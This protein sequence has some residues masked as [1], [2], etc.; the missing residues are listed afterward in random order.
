M[1]LLPAETQIEG[2]WLTLAGKTIADD[3]CSRINYLLAK[4]LTRVAA[5]SDGWFILYRDNFDNRLWELT[6]PQSELHGGGPPR[7]CNLTPDEAAAK[8]VLDI[9]PN[10]ES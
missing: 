8:Y 10:A 9:K 4:E 3:N 5:T 6:Y 2:R 1:R 7:L